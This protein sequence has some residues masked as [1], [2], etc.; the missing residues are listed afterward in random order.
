MASADTWHF[1][2][3]QAQNSS[4]SA[5]WKLPMILIANMVEKMIKICQIL[6]SKKNNPKAVRKP[7]FIKNG[8]TEPI[9]THIYDMASS[10]NRL[11]IS[12]SAIK[13][14]AIYK[15]PQNFVFLSSGNG[16]TLCISAKGHTKRRTSWDR[17]EMAGFCQ[18]TCTWLVKSCPC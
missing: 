1:C 8:R 9:F 5:I 13:I 18:L 11:D 6:F 17:S 15:G 16:A 4:I 2:I 12:K 7:S 3:H 14:V 10:G